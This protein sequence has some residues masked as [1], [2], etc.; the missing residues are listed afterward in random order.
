MFI[1]L[2]IRVFFKEGIVYIINYF[3]GVCCLNFWGRNVKGKKEILVECFLDIIKL[4]GN[5]KS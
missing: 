5:N 1:D 3:V 2:V 4:K